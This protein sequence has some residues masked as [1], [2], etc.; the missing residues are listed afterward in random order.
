MAWLQTQKCFSP[1]P[2]LSNLIN[3]SRGETWEKA[4]FP[5]P[6]KAL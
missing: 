6:L 4:Y 2:S 1:L 5:F 3:V